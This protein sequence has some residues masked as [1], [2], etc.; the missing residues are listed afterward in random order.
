MRTLSGREW[1]GCTV[2]LSGLLLA[3]VGGRREEHPVPAHE[4]SVV[5]V[6]YVP[7]PVGVAVRPSMVGSRHVPN[8]GRAYRPARGQAPVPRRRTTSA[9]AG[10]DVVSRPPM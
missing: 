5:A 10:R 1:A 2:I 6:G 3:V 4:V 8:L 7:M 9:A